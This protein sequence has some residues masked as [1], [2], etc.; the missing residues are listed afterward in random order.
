MA[1]ITDINPFCSKI[2]INLDMQA[3]RRNTDPLPNMINFFFALVNATFI[4]LAS[5]R[6]VFPCGETRKE[7]NVIPAKCNNKL[8]PWYLD[9]GNSNLTYTLLYVNC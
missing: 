9:M 2:P 8:L 3:V 5:S 4:L 7:W 6:M 1:V